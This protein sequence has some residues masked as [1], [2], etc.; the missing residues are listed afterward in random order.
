MLV[1]DAFDPVGSEAVLQQGGALE[2]LAHGN[3]ASGEDLLEIVPAGGGPG[4]T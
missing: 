1:A 4:G 2:G 3:F